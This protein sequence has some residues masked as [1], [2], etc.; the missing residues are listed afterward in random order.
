MAI[1]TTVMT[2]PASGPTI[3]KPRIRPSPGEMS[4]FMN[5]CVSPIVRARSTPAIGSLATSTAT[6]WRCA[7]LSRSPICATCGSV[8]KQDGISRPLVVRCPPGEVVADDSEIIQ[9]GVRERRTPR[10]FA[11]R[12][13]IRRSGFEPVV[14]PHKAA[15]SEFHAGQFQ[16]DTRRIGRPARGDKD[17]AGNDRSLSPGSSHRQP[18]L[19]PGSPFR[20]DNLRGCNHVDSIRHQ[21]SLYLAQTRPRLR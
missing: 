11:D 1:C 13:D 2:S 5:P 18:D 10:A 12:P 7:S 20:T 21:N 14:H 4:A 16:S 17:V 6:P 15:R 9:R 8:N 19:G 3:V